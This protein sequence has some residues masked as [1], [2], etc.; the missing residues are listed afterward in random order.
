MGPGHGG[1]IEI[2]VG[3]AGRRSC[4]DRAEEEWDGRAQRWP[5]IWVDWH[6]VALVGGALCAVRLDAWALTVDDFPKSWEGAVVFTHISFGLAVLTLLLGRLGWR[7]T[8]PPPPPLATPF[9]PWVGIAAL[10]VHVLIYALL[11]MVPLVGIVPAVCARAIAAVVRPL[12]NRFTLGA[13]PHAGRLGEE[14]AR[15]ARQRSADSRVASCARR[16]RPP[17]CAERR[18]ASSNAAGR[19]LPP[20]TGGLSPLLSRASP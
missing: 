7:M 9:D 4:A 17:L 18:H 5:T 8:S 12:R 6:A 3:R 2:K 13:R 16:P 10:S 19:R 14:R 1:L 15:A 11:L 20:L